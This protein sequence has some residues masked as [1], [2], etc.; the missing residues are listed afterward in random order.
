MTDWAAPVIRVA[1]TPVLD[2]MAIDN[3][4]SLVPRES[5]VDFAGQLL[6]VLRGLDRIDQDAWGRAGQVFAAH[7]AP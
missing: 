4:P 3:L 5:S 2:V 7:A 6:P 1:E